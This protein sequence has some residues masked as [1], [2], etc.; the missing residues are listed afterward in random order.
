MRRSDS[1]QNGI[2]L[3]VIRAV[4]WHG[5]YNM[6]FVELFFKF[7]FQQFIIKFHSISFLHH[8]NNNESKRRKKHSFLTRSVVPC[9]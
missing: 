3:F 7:E 8:N 9:S 6:R 4:A 5:I 1:K 2:E